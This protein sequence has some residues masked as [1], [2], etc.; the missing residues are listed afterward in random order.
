V[1]S[2]DEPAE[3]G[4]SLELGGN[5]DEKLAEGVKGIVIASSETVSV[6]YSEYLA[7]CHCHP[8]SDGYP[9]VTMHYATSWTQLHMRTDLRIAASLINSNRCLVGCGESVNFE[10]HFA[11]LNA[12][13]LRG[14]LAVQAQR[15]MVVSHIA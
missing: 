1:N 5:E 14:S 10:I 6:S 2:I 7:N 8:R 15:L 3:P 4:F 12:R 13:P 11:L 9:W